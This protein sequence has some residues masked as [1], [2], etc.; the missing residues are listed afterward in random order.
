MVTAT[1]AND[2]KAPMKNADITASAE[3]VPCVFA[4]ARPAV[5]AVQAA[6][7]KKIFHLQKQGRVSIS[8]RNRKSAG[9]EEVSI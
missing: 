2:S 1:P 7:E 9:K 8:P 4:P 6:T 3:A 5:K